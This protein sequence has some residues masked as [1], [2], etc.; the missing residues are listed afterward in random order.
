[1][2]KKIFTLLIVFLISQIGFAQIVDT[3][4]LNNFFEALDSNQRFMGSVAISENGKIIYTNEIGFSDV[5][6]KIKPNIN[7]TYKIGSISKMFTATL[8]FKAVEENEIKLSDKID[9]YFPTI[10]NAKIISIGN[11]LN[12]RSGIHNFTNDSEY[13]TYNTQ[14]KSEKQLLEIFSKMKSDFEPGSK[15]D[16]SNSNYVLLSF[17]LEKIYKVDYSTLLNSRIIKPLGLKHTYFG[18]PISIKDNESYSYSY[19]GSWVKETETDMSIPIGAGAIVST[20]SDLTKFADALFNGKILSKSSLEQMKIMEDDYGMGLFKVPFFKKIGYGHTGGIDGFSSVL[21]H[22]DDQ[23]VSIAITS[24]GTRF[25][26]NEI[27][28]ALLSSVYNVPID[29]PSFKSID[30][31]SE[32]LDKYLGVYSSSEI[33]IKITITKNGKILS[34]QA[35]GQSS[36]PLDAPEK[37]IFIFK[38]AGVVLEFSSDGKNMHLKQRGGDLSFTKE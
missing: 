14:K 30:L 12:H 28:I 22:F 4:K 26:N 6:N 33:P 7:T 19:N 18:K 27:A 23:N 1:M 20:P 29:I 38:Q 5:E 15:A 3:S 8:V 34:A 10:K 13:I 37:N 31:T 17:L 21:Y 24:N 11:L 9:K 25:S 36:F 35:T 32:D 2:N 16:Y